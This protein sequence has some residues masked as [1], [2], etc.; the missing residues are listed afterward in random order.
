[1]DLVDWIILSLITIGIGMLLAIFVVD[2]IEDERLEILDQ[3]LEKQGYI[4]WEEETRFNLDYITVDMICYNTQTNQWGSMTAKVGGY[5]VS[6]DFQPGGGGL[7][8]KD[9]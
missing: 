4:C 3:E 8:E 5:G 9:Y 7:I 2:S 6:L 1:M